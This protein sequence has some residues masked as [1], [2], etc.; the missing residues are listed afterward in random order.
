MSS[1]PDLL[2][3]I[4]KLESVM[5]IILATIGN[6]S[7]KIL[8]EE[9]QE[10]ADVGDLGG[11]QTANQ[12]GI[13]IR[14][15]AIKICNSCGDVIEGKF[16]VCPVDKRIAC[17]SCVCRFNQ[18]NICKECLKNIRPLSKPTYKILLAILNNI[19]NQKKIHD[20]TKIPKD[21]LRDSMIFLKENGYIMR[22]GLSG[23]KISESGANILTA[24]KQ[25]YNEEDI[26][27]LE[28]EIRRHLGLQ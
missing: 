26:T 4:K 23:Y 7:K 6:G 12:D 3:R 28:L 24:Y 11:K 2:N 19:D 1:D 21:D 10:V 5:E 27:S 17:P 15:S 18:Q 9:K 22:K 8:I 25:V 14:T 13:I 20:L 16:V